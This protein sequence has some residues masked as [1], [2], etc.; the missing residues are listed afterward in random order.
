MLF[1]SLEQNFEIKFAFQ[2]IITLRYYL[3]EAHHIFISQLAISLYTISTT[4]IL[5]LFTNN[6]IVGYFAAADKIIQA[7]KS[8]MVP[9]SQ[10]LYPYMASKFQNEEKKFFSNN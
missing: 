7:F 6:T 5:G 3:N 4:F 10:A 1:I 9:V 8:L 2:K